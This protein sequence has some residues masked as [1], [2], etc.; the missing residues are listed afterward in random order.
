MLEE[1]QRQRSDSLQRRGG[2]GRAYSPPP[3]ETISGAAEG[4]RR[5]ERR[6]AFKTGGKGAFSGF[7]SAGGIDRGDGRRPAAA[8]TG[9]KAGV[10]DSLQQRKR[11]QAATEAAAAV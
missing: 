3:A 7:N 2:R 5:A 10:S 4:W 11:S 1:L 8:K 6:I 9:R